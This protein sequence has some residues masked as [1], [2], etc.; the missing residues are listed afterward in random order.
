MP[1]NLYDNFPQY[2]TA[3]ADASYSFDYTTRV[4]ISATSTAT[5]KFPMGANVLRIRS[6]TVEDVTAATGGSAPALIACYYR[7]DGQTASAGTA[8]DGS[9]SRIVKPGERQSISRNAP[10]EGGITF[11]NPNAAAVVLQIEL[12]A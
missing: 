7:I 10:A 1:G 12:G 9:A 2:S 6:I 8:S 5:A 11:F 3:I 4:S